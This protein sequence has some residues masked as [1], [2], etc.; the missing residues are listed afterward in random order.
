MSVCGL[1][2]EFLLC[3]Q[4]FNT[5]YSEITMKVHWGGGHSWVVG[6][7][8]SS[9]ISD[10]FLILNIWLLWSVLTKDPDLI[11][12]N[13]AGRV[14]SLALDSFH[15]LVVFMLWMSSVFEDEQNKGTPKSEA[16]LTLIMFWLFLSSLF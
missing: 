11:S 14:Q 3:I 4:G 8:L 2:Y 12:R 6:H 5:F 1:N 10:L 13:D 7:T 16:K 15:L 9:I